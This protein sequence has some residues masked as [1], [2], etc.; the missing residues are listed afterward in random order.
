MYFITYCIT[1]I[2]NKILI[3][4]RSIVKFFWASTTLSYYTLTP[5]F[6]FLI[7]AMGGLLNS[8][9]LADLNFLFY[10]TIGYLFEFSLSYY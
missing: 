3:N 8:I 7:D 2:K 5:L 6:M 4:Q 9:I 1:I 10:I